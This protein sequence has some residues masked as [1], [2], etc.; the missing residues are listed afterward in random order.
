MNNV[1]N[2]DNL[3]KYMRQYNNPDFPFLEY[4]K[5]Y[6]GFNNGVLN[7]ITCEFSEESELN[8]CNFIV[9]KYI[10]KPF[11]YSLETPLMDSVLNY[12]FDKEV[13][14]FIYTCLG[15]MF[16]IRDNFGFMLYL[17]GEAG[18]G[19][20]L[21]IN[22]LSA[23]FN[24]IG[25]VSDSFETKYGLGYLYNK[26]IIVC[27]DLPKDINKIFPQQIFQSCITQGTISTAVK[28]GDAPRCFV[29]KS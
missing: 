3:I 10:D 13:T 9:K 24:N 6:I 17:L 26:D 5:D 28:N 19:K 22:I 8:N 14:S 21:I 20:S 7:I 29:T 18:T 4:N 11:E 27:D 2:M 15:R 16:G 1:N 12:Q 25:A 23:C